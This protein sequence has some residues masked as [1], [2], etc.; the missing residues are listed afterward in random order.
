MTKQPPKKVK[1]LTRLR[2]NEVSAVDRGAGER[3]KIVLSKRDDSADDNHPVEMPENERR[4]WSALGETALRHAE[5]RYRKANGTGAADHEP[6]DDEPENPFAKIFSGTKIPESSAAAM[7]KVAEQL[8]KSYAAV[9][10]GDEADRH[11]GEVSADVIVA[12][13]DAVPAHRRPIAFD[14]TDGAR[15]KFPNERSLAEWLAIMRRLG[16]RKSNNSEEPTMSIDLSAIVKSY[17]ILALA[18]HLASEGKSFGISESE[19]TKLATE[20]AQRRFP[21]DRSDVAF[22][23]LYSSEEGASLRSAIEIA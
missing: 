13:D 11:D 15:M 17:G 7:T 14:T 9:A 5:E 1:V 2:I 8:N 16:I 4:Y 21:T 18:K 23:K 20:D 6:A 19:L 3:C 12:S 10:R 22:A